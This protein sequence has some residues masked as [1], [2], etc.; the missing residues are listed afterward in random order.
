[1]GRLADSSNVNIEGIGFRV[2]NLTMVLAWVAISMIDLPLVVNDIID[3]E[4]CLACL[5]AV[6]KSVGSMGVWPCFDT[7]MIRILS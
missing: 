6:L 1:V 3:V 4:I 2:A 5:M 7:T